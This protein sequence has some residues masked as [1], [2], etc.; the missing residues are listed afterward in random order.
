MTYT[1]QH[2]IAKKKHSKIHAPCHIQEVCDFALS[3]KWDDKR[4]QERGVMKRMNFNQS[5]E[6][7]RRD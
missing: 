3:Q 6:Y 5:V 4:Q 2:K 1:Q 7:C